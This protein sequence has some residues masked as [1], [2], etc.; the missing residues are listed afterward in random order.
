[1]PLWRA[2]ARSRLHLLWPEGQCSATCGV[3]RAGAAVPLESVFPSAQGSVAA[4]GPTLC[5]DWG[6][7][8]WILGAF[9]TAVLVVAAK[10]AAA[11][12][13]DVVLQGMR[14]HLIGS[15]AVPNSGLSCS[16]ERA[17]WLKNA[18][19]EPPMDY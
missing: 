19:Y 5:L 14:L 1:M 17:N 6:L 12:G 15:P 4:W 18:D 13:E 8:A 10:S 11:D 9:S 3:E 7:D 16:R 2:S